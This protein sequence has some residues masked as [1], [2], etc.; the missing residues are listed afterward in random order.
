MKKYKLKIK[1]IP[2]LFVLMGEKEYIL[3]HGKDSNGITIKH[4]QEVHINSK[5][6]TKNLIAHELWHAYIASCCLSSTEDLGQD[7]M[8]EVG[9]ELVE[10]HLDE[11]V[12]NRNKI[13][14]GLG[15]K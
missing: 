5:A 3:E 14:R 10:F 2:W 13:Y 6:F 9:A 12:S 7:N 4:K 1:S 11:M 8:E 15:G